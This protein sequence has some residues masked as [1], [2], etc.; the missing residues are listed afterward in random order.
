[1]KAVQDYREQRV[2][3][4]A[5]VKILIV[6][7]H[8]VVRDGLQ[9]MLEQEED[10]EIVGQSAGG[11]ETL[12]QI[13]KLSPNVVLMDIKM[14]RV[15]GIELTRQVKQKHPSCNVVMLTLYEQYL[16]EAME[17]GAS[18]Y[19][20]KDIKCDELAQAIRQVHSGQVV[21]S[22]NIKSKTQFRYEDRC[23]KKAE[24]SS[25]TMVEEIQ[26]ALPPPVEAT[27]LMRLAGRAEE[28]LQ[29][30]VLQMVG[31]WQE[32]TVMTI[33]LSEATSLASVLN[34]F[35]NMPEVETVGE[36]P[37]GG[38]ISPKLLKKAEDMPRLKN[39]IRKTIFVALE[40][41]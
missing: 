12:S 26:V 20:L 30:R 28:A 14:P 2:N 19:L 31:A 27:Q 41:N 29:S 25:G 4:K 11:E 40:K 36:E 1:M 24:E 9:H 21:T 10:L 37:L 39:R 32:G 38:E 18:G 5:G 7:D 33:I 15:D 8:Q 35:K 13:E 22:E 23:S 3:V 6:D 17:A 16:T 34:M